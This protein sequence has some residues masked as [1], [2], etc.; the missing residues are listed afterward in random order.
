M[1]EETFKLTFFA[2]LE[3]PNFIGINYESVC[4]ANYRP[5]IEVQLR[6]KF[7]NDLLRI[8]TSN[9]WTNADFPEKQIENPNEEVFLVSRYAT[10]D[11]LPSIKEF[12]QKHN[13]PYLHIEQLETVVELCTELDVPKWLYEAI[14][15]LGFAP[16][17]LPQLGFFN[18]EVLPN[19]AAVV[20]RYRVATLPALRHSVAP[21]SENLVG[22]A[23]IEIQNSTGKI[24][25]QS[26]HGFDIRDHER[27]MQHHV[28]NLGV[29]SRF[30]S[31]INN[32]ERFEF[33]SQFCS[34]YYLFY[35]R[36]WA[37]AVTI[38]SGVVDSLVREAV[39]AKLSKSMA[40][41]LWK[42][43]KNQTMELFK[44]VLPALGYSKLSI[45]DKALWD[46]FIKA[47]EHRG[48]VAHGSPINS[49][50]YEQ[51]RTVRDHLRA[52]YGV[53]RW[54]SIQNGR[55]WVLDIEANFETLSFF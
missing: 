21:V 31:L 20:N 45:D 46:C 35:M 43:Y 49:F 15:K 37:E 47:K 23:F 19:I 18:S 51:E 12:V 30:D 48:S 55:P 5:N 29:Q 36:R 34:S 2:W 32:P 10:K 54:L 28:E 6:I 9:R 17:V 11:D 22:T 40:D 25:Q 53:A 14:T 4:P 1:Q 33:E 3:I 13:L 24:I 16:E 26:G 44:E 41:L 7:R 27:T 52:L 39:F 8:M 50:D 38:A 42:K